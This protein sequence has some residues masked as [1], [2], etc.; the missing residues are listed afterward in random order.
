MYQPSS[1]LIA[2]AMRPER[3]TGKASPLPFELLGRGVE[4]V[5]ISHGGR[6]M[7][8]TGHF[9]DACALPAKYRHWKAFAAVRALHDPRGLFHNDWT[10]LAFSGI[11]SPDQSYRY[12]HGRLVA[13]DPTE[14]GSHDPWPTI[15][16]PMR[17]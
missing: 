11:S 15:P 12:L 5:V 16:T 17:P 14:K 8:G 6:P 7:W 2:L 3:S 1:A 9:V 13:L 4:S 10:T